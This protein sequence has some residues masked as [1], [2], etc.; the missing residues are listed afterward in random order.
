MYTN[1]ANQMGSD[2]EYGSCYSDIM[3]TTSGA[4][5]AY[6]RI[7]CDW[8]GDHPLLS[9]TLYKELPANG[10]WDGTSS[11]PKSVL[12]CQSKPNIN[13]VP[14]RSLHYARVEQQPVYFGLYSNSNVKSCRRGKSVF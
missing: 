7:Y 3:F 12:T 14:T 4:S 1:K 9:T 11:S 5:D 8:T 10:M 6:T 13:R 2:G